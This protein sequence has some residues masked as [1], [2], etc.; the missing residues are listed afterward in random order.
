MRMLQEGNQQSDVVF[1]YNRN[2][3][4]MD[5]GMVRCPLPIEIGS[6]QGN[7]DSLKKYSYRPFIC[8]KQFV[9]TVNKFQAGTITYIH[10]HRK[11]KVKF[12]D[13]NTEVVFWGSFIW[14]MYGAIAVGEGPWIFCGNVDWYEKSY[15]EKWFFAGDDCDEEE[16]SDSESVLDSD[17][18]SV[19][20]NDSDCVVLEDSDD[21]DEDSDCVVLE[22]SDD[23]D[24]DSDSDR[25]V[26]EDSDIECVTL[27]DSD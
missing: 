16:D 24:E 14:D 1:F 3:E 10:I 7:S 21:A 22:G 15:H 20:D 11:L 17:S 25:V 13:Q 5:S 23:T 6:G 2:K 8:V 26:Y 19:L 18:E 12:F 9:I 4:C 27:E